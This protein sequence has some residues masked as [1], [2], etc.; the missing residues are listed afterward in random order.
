MA[1]T[2]SQ[3]DEEPTTSTARKGKKTALGQRRKSS[4]ATVSADAKMPT[5]EDDNGS[6]IDSN[7]RSYLGEVVMIDMPIALKS[8]FDYY[9]SEIRAVWC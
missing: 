7:Y 6:A 5:D 8:K 3:I 9:H 2:N 4:I 1:G